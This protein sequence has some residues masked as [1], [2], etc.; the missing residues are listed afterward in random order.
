M[1][2]HPTSTTICATSPPKGISR[3]AR[4]V[5]RGHRDDRCSWETMHARREGPQQGND[6]IF[7]IPRVLD[8][9]EGVG[10]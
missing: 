3:T 1:S 4:E 8:Y 2:P 7:I 5:V 10:A 6:E 9:D